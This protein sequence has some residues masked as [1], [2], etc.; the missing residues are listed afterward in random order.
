MPSYHVRVVEYSFSH[1]GASLDEPMW[2]VLERQVG[3]LD[4]LRCDTVVRLQPVS[5]CIQHRSRP[6]L[7]FTVRTL[8]TTENRRHINFHAELRYWLVCSV[9]LGHT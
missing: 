1:I 6:F 5:H 9:S 2:H 3:S 4:Q 8:T 7:Y